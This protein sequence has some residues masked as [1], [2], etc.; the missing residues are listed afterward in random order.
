MGMSNKVLKPNVKE[1]KSLQIKS[2]SNNKSN[3]IMELR[4]T[5]KKNPGKVRKQFIL[6]GLDCA[7]CASKIE[8][9][10]NSIDGIA[11]ASVNFVTKTLTMELEEISK[12]NELIASSIE[13]INKIE[14]HVKVKEK[15]V[16]KS[17]KLV[18]ILEGL[19]CANCA[20]KNLKILLMLVVL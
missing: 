17:N 3:T 16:G 19:C 20:S 5:T 10:L 8:T 1:D 14:S 11:N 2:Q 18:I 12:V 15:S 4:T 6:E 9:K 13:S 7:H